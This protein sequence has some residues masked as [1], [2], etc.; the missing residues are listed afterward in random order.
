[1]CLTVREGKD[2]ESLA[3]GAHGKSETFGDASKRR[4]PTFTCF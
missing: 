2:E 3:S 1:L 4:S